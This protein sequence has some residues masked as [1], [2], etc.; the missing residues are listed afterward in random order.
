M[1]TGID[2]SV[3]VFVFMPLCVCVCVCVRV[4]VRVYTFFWRREQFVLFNDDVLLSKHK[5]IAYFWAYRK[6]L[7]E[8][9]YLLETI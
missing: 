2:M 8:M 4:R 3:H 6:L 5:P 1:F 7:K 9:K